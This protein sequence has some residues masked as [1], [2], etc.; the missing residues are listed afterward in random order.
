MPSD[1]KKEREKKKK[2]KKMASRSLSGKLAKKKGT[3]IAKK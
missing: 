1:T 2:K 3:K